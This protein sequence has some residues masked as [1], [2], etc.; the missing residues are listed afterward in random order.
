MLFNV[1]TTKQC[2]NVRHIAFTLHKATD[3]QTHLYKTWKRWNTFSISHVLLKI[4]VEML[5]PSRRSSFEIGKFFFEN[6]SL[7]ELMCSVLIAC[8]V[9]LYVG[10]SGLCCCVP[11]VRVT[12][13]FRALSTLWPRLA[14]TAVGAIVC[15]SAPLAA[16][17]VPG[18]LV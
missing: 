1:D 14:A 18:V 13:V 11:V 2:A 15:H 10:G 17:A 7:M 4:A 6:V 3:G 12:S 8:Q 5:P 16:R 9:A